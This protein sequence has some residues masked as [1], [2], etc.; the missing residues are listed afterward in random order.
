MVSK[1]QECTT[2]S[3]IF[4]LGERERETARQREREAEYAQCCSRPELLVI[5]MGSEERQ[6]VE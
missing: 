5:R 6:A 2:S 4:S 3:L 1:L